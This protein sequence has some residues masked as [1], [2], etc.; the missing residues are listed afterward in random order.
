MVTG[1][2]TAQLSIVLVDARHGMVE[3]SRRHA[4]IASLLRIPHLVFAVNK[5]DLVGWSE[6]V[7]R[8][9]EDEFRDFASRLDVQDIA[10]IPMSALTGANVVDRSVEM[11]W[12]HGPTLLYQLETVYIAG[13][14][15]L[16]D[17]RFPV[18]W[19]I[20]PQSDEHHDYR[21]YARP[22]RGRRHALR[23]RRRSCCRAACGRRSREDRARAASR[24]TP[25]T[26][27]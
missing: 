22:G 13:D 12:F 5:M 8:K 26:R 21:G 27:R 2:S 3:Q 4:Y 20:R 24:S 10:F 23:R 1:A 17:V 14:R 7:F 6:D 19:V 15:N 11:P 18:Q 16:I 25:R 9:I